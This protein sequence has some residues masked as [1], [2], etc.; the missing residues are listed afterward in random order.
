MR[1]SDFYKNVYRF[2]FLFLFFEINGILLLHLFIQQA[3]LGEIPFFSFF[4]VYV[5]TV[6]ACNIKLKSVY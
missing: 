6:H 1:N 5:L 4:F 2:L 3:F